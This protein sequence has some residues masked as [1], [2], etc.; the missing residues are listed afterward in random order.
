MVSNFKCAE[1][2][3]KS[4]LSPK[5]VLVIGVILS[6]LYLVNITQLKKHDLGSGSAD[7]SFTGYL[8]Y[9]IR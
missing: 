8:P 4:G 2:K 6:I 5:S 9:K 3:N 1:P 7:A